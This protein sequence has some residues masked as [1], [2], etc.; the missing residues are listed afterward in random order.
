MMHRAADPANVA[1]RSSPS[2]VPITAET[3]TQPTLIPRAIART[4]QDPGEHDRAPRS[5]CRA[6]VPRLASRGLRD[7]AVVRVVRGEQRADHREQRQGEEQEQPDH[8]GQVTAYPAWRRGSSRPGQWYRL[9]HLQRGSP[10]SMICSPRSAIANPRIHQ[11]VG[12]VGQQVDQ[13]EDHRQD[14]R[15]RLHQRVVAGVDRR[16]S[17]GSPHRASRRPPR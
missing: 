2:I 12:D 16:R 11:H 8:Q 14:Q 6:G 15:A 3:S 1:R 9:G 17:A 13:H 4:V 5:R 7:V 10:I